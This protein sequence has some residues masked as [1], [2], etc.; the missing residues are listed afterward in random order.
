MSAER[1]ELP[2][3]ESLSLLR[4]QQV[5]RMCVVDHGFPLALPLNYKVIG[6]DDAC[7][8]VVRTGPQTI[9]GRSEGPASL[10][11]DVVDDEARVAWSVIVRGQLRHVSGAHGLPDPGPWLDGRHHWM[12]LTS[13]AVTGRRFVGVPG[14]DVFSVDWQLETA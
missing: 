9:I 10:E 8:V 4:S 6:P 5:G 3:W 14:A 12:V 7:Q 13:T 1:V 11:V 2:T